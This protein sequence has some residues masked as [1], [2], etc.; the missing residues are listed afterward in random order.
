IIDIGVPRDFPAS[1]RDL[2][3][4]SYHDVD[5]LQAVAARNGDL[6]RAEVEAVN[7]LVDEETE[8]FRDWWEQLQIVPTITA[9][10]DRADAL[11]RI[12]IAKTLRRLDLD[13][14]DREHVEELVDVLSRAIVKQIFA[15]PIAVLRERGDR[16]VYVDAVRTLFRLSGTREQA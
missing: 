12:E 5:D 7:T 14:E 11:R 16:D 13:G 10:H 6:R 4:V 1:V 3:G 2:P 8:R 9:L 15:D